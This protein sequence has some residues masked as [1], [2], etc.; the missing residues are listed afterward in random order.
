MNDFINMPEIL[1]ASWVP[2]NSIIKV[3]GVGGGGCNAVTYMYNQKIQGCNFIVC[4][5]D[6][7]ALQKSNVPIKIQLGEGLGAGTNPTKGRNAALDSQD[8]I[9]EKVLDNGTQMLFIT[10]GMGGGTGTGASPVIA[11]M[12]KDKGI[13]TVAVVTLP[14]KNEGDESLSKAVEGI[15]ELESNVDS[16]LIINNEKLYEFFGDQL[17]QDAFP[18]ADEVLATA[19][20][21]ITEIISKPGYINVDF[22][23]V[24]T[25]MKNSGLALMGCGTGSGPNRLEDA[26]KGAL[27]SPLLSDFDLKT[28]KNLLINI[29]A[30]ENEQ[31]LKME[32][33]NKI[34]DMINEHIGNVNKFK[35]GLIWDEDSNDDTIRIT[36]IATGFKMNL[37]NLAGSDMGKLI[38]IEKDFTYK[39]EEENISSGEITLP[40]EIININKVGYSTSENERKFHFNSDEKPALIL[41]ENSNRSD[42]ENI[43]A[44]RRVARHPKTNE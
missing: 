13:L 6:S 1:E 15:H 7:Q 37:I 28:A 35:R 42:L 23:D 38:L 32:E 33:L 34:N 20:R 12:A 3:I 21:G 14:F 30:G 19:V 17:V 29:T 24:K 41:S 10:A 31:G 36:A 22:E 39:K 9:A 43:A 11:K 4:N 25:M 16:L 40:D 2:E 5:T 18:R 44:I 27:E 8:I 26:V